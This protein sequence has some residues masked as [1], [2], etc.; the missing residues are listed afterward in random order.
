MLLEFKVSNYRSI[1][2]EQVLNLVPSRDRGHPQNI[3][4][5][6]TARALSTV[7]I[8]GAN[9]SGKSNLFR[10][11]RA[12]C[13]FVKTSATKMNAGDP[14]DACQPFAFDT[15]T[16]SQPS[17]FTFSLELDG[18]VYVYNFSADK[19][20]VYR[21]SLSIQRKASIRP[22]RVFDRLL[23]IK[24]IQNDIPEYDWKFGSLLNSGL[25]TLLRERTRSNCLT[26]SRAGEQNVK[27]MMP[28]FKWFSQRAVWLDMA[29]SSDDLIAKTTKRAHQNKDIREK[30]LALLRNCD[31][32]ISLLDFDQRRLVDSMDAH[33]REALQ[34]FLTNVIPED[35][36]AATDA[37]LDL[38]TLTETT[39][40]TF[41]S[42]KTGEM[43]PFSMKEESQGT[44]RLF[45]LGGPF[46]DAIE[47]GL[48]LFVDEMDASLH[49]LLTRQ[50]VES[51]R[52][53]APPQKAQLVFITHDTSLFRSDIFRRDQIYLAEMNSMG[54]SEFF[55]LADFKTTKRAPRSTEDFE[56]NYLLG[57]YGG[58]PD[59][60]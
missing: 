26:L 42:L 22:S 15:E 18:D 12:A 1:K 59:L 37:K 50:L 11:F 23:V 16:Q 48:F 43:V 10:A 7:A 56:K 39:V 49:P 45:A 24:T 29:T 51:F 33:Q 31:L 60:S 47:R 41:H 32:P 58:I 8:Y 35:V 13:R 3:L 52:R 28:L 17:S 6:A 9:A 21:E 38:D 27:E 53:D 14:T 25:Q 2:D 4:N 46:A 36:R 19:Q 57:R 20:H 44:Q 30:I 5:G 54:A 34:T 55:S 40:R